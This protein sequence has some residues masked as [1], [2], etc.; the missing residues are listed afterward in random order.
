M[1]PDSTTN[2][3][4]FQVQE[5][6]LFMDNLLTSSLY[7]MQ[8]RASWPLEGSFI[9]LT[10]IWHGLRHILITRVGASYIFQNVWH[11]GSLQVKIYSHS[12]F[13]FSSHEIKYLPSLNCE[14]DRMKDASYPIEKPPPPKF[15]CVIQDTAESCQ[16]ARNVHDFWRCCQ[17]VQSGGFSRVCWFGWDW[18]C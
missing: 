8:V 4:F 10:S 11:P 2:E 6:A 14:A 3:L 12:S 18:G 16:R 1:A 9:K 7:L 15:L 13:S 5:I 17:W